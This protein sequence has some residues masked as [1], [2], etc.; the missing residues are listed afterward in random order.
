MKYWDSVKVPVVVSGL[1]V[2]NFST[3]F[4]FSNRLSFELS[5]SDAASWPPKRLFSCIDNSTESF[6]VKSI[7]SLW[8]DDTSTIT[9][10]LVGEAARKCRV[11]VRVLDFSL[12]GVNGFEVAREGCPPIPNLCLLNS[13]IWSYSFLSHWYYFKILWHIK[14][15]KHCWSVMSNNYF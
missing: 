7:S 2:W 6:L 4:L 11:G 3:S 15:E 14:L 5:F 1:I 10:E 9:D 8:I 13:E 12:D